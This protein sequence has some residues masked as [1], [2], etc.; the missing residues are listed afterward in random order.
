VSIS[1]GDRLQPV[2]WVARWHRRGA[3]ALPDTHASFRTTP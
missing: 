2:S 3:Y 1:A